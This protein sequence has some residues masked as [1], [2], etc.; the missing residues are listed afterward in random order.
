MCLVPV[1]DNQG[2][3]SIREARRLLSFLPRHRMQSLRVLAFLSLIPGFLDFASIAI[4]GRLTG[5]LVGGNLSNLLPG[6][7]IFG[8]S[9]L[10]QS[11]WLI[12]LFVCLTWI[13]SLMRIVLRLAQERTASQIW[14]DLSERIFCGIIYQ[15]YEYHLSSNLANLSSD[16]LGSLDCLLKEIVTPA[17]RALSSL[18][19]IL[20]IT[21][22][23]IYIGRENAVWLLL[24][25]VSGYILTT[26]LMTPRLRFSSEQKLR[27]RDRFI[28]VFFESF[29]SIRDVKLVKAEAFFTRS[30]SESTLEYKIAD[31]QLQV[32]PEV[33]RM[34]IEALGITVI[35]ILGVLPK[36]LSG[37]QQQVFD[38]L[39][40]L[41]VLS[42]GALRLTKSLQDLFTAIARLRGGLPEL[43]AI[44]KLL[45]LQDRTSRKG[46][47][48]Q[49]LNG[50]F[51]VRTISLKNASYRYPESDRW[52]LKDISLSIPVGSRVAFVGPTGSGKS[53]AAHLLLGLLFPQK[54]CL[55][56]DGVPVDEAEIDSWYSC[57]S[58]VPQNIQLYNG[59]VYA[60]VA[61]GEEEKNIN[62]DRVWDALE[63]AQVNEFVADL[64][65][66]IH[67]QIGDNGI[68]LSGGQRQRIALARAFYRHS[69][70][71]VLDEATSALDNQTESDVIQ[72]LEIVGRRCT[73]LVIAHRLTTIQRCDRIYEFSDGRII[74][75]G[76]YKSLQKSSESFRRLVQLQYVGGDS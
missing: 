56:I 32:L 53:T 52:V 39:P 40:F 73:T 27:T 71:L 1:G 36:L 46:L 60:N 15:P 8:G 63:A 35:F 19:S 65:Y 41:A 69:R 11:L 14:L 28:Q 49:S 55:S 26:S 57:C 47:L 58:Q 37:D 22:G 23:I 6:I 72:S 66:G 17:L 54:G 70:F 74:N 10:E 64:P 45:A 2:G 33:P 20:I 62:F 5:S 38:I 61:F 24:V 59:S 75:S 31:T 51:P 42:I 12:G 30:F 68:K 76:D 25:M 13:Q 43:T 48:N 7:R 21:I 29:R 16:L 18:V 9:K 44:N 4:V 50:L 34:L 67:T 3:K